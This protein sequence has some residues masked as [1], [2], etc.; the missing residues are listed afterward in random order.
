MPP[1]PSRRAARR[2][3]LALALAAIVGA[4][5]IAGCGSDDGGDA[6][7]GDTAAEGSDD[8]IVLGYSA[9]PGWFPWKVA[10]EQGILQEVGVEVELKWFDDYLQSLT[11]LS[12]GQLDGNSQTLNDTLVGVSAG[13]DQVVVL[14]NDNSAGNDAIIVD[15][16]INSIEDLRG[17][18]IAAEPGVVD[19]FLLLQGLDSVG[20]TE[21]DIQFSGLPTADAAAAFSSGQ[22]DA[23]GV[24]APFTLQALERAGS[25]VLFDSADFPGSIP[26]FLVLNRSVVEE[27]P[28]DVQ[29]LIDA[30]YLTQEWIAAHPDEANEIMA[31]Q[32]GI[33]P[34]EYASLA[35][36]TRI[37]TAEEA[38]A[39]LNGTAPTDLGPMAEKVAKFLPASG[40]VEEEP[41][42]DGLFDPSFT[43]DY[44]ER[45]GG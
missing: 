34:D 31:K 12:A 6:A 37:F 43:E 44:I 33:S 24:F 16:S 21:A 3:W 41:S 10:E 38:L 36:G 40:L 13:D 29:K 17:K 7:S 8:P 23:T 18:S 26:D 30:W 28:E 4:G 22:F 19:H 11:A 35:G 39:S 42:L 27:R 1:T 14:V 5:A 9:W 32:A 20:M 25:K 2:R 45:Q 15:A